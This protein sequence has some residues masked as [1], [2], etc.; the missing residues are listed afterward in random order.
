MLAN[1][2]EDYQSKGLEQNDLHPDPIGQFNIWFREALE[3]GIKEPNAM[4]LA[5]C[6]PDGKPSARI[7]LLKDV[8]S[9]GFTFFTNYESRKAQELAA[10][11]Y[12]ALVFL[13]L[14][15]E[16]QV[17]IEGRVE[18]VSAAESEAYFQSRPKG[19]QTGAWASPQSKVIESRAILEARVQ[20]LNQQYE[21]VEK[22][23]LPNFWGGYLVKPEMIEFWQGRTSRLHDRF[24][25]TLQADETW[26]MERLAP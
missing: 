15:L 25:Y 23:P 22:L 6:S 17:R 7:V 19:S 26:K 20:H 2:R 16:R 14:G 12:A 9:T 3:K 8:K 11:P 18:K 21:N 13:W 10:N 24:R 5:T 4:T 1:L